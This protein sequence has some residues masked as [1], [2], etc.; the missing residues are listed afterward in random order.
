VPKPVIKRS[1]LFM[2]FFKNCVKALKLK[3]DPSFMRVHIGVNNYMISKNK[4]FII[5]RA[6]H[7]K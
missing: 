2:H 7:T 5:Q 6:L 3:G 4:N 1:V